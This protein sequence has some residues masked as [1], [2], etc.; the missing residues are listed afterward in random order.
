[1][2][3]SYKNFFHKFQIFMIL[4]L[5][6]I[7]LAVFPIALLAEPLLAYIW[8]LPTLYL[9]L[10]LVS[11][12]IPGKL[13]L[14]YGIAGMVV[15]LFT[16]LLISK[17][18][19]GSQAIP[20][21]VSGF[22]GIL[23]I[24]SLQIAGW[25]REKELP[26]QY[27][28]Y[29]L[30][31]H[32]VG[33]FLMGVDRNYGELWAKI[34]PWLNAALFAFAGLVMISMNRAGLKAATQK[35]QGASASIRGKNLLLTLALFGIA[36]LAACIPSMIGTV[37]YTFWRVSEW[38]NKILS[39]IRQESDMPF[40]TETQIP[41][42]ESGEM[43]TLP[44]NPAD[45]LVTEITYS[46]IIVLGV[47]VLTPVVILAF[48]RI[49]KALGKLFREVWN[50]L[51]YTMFS[52]SEDGYEDEIT[53]TRDDDYQLE[54]T[55]KKHSERIKAALVNEQKLSPQQR[56]RHYYRRLTLKHTEWMRGNTARETLSAQAAEI[57]E[58]ARYSSHPISEEDAAAFKKN[59]RKI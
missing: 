37:A 46:I 3:P 2:K 55:P 56:V 33:Q 34:T 58:R 44:Y 24:V 14:V 57:Y 11:L 59:T 12:M 47:I 20:L 10:T 51:Q 36:L 39:A 15:L 53:D 42:T 5:G 50:W 21:A 17:E 9:I 43:E 54:R 52:A 7:P 22:Y 18:S 8:I 6:T 49:W 38:V 35:R 41:S 23:L 32:L 25:E 26:I 40:P 48:I 30:A 29:C 13:R 19:A 16:G 1:M 4:A 27:A 28:C 45:P 31:L